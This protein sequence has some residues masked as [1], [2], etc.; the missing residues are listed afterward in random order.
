LSKLGS[1]Y[2]RFG[3]HKKPQDPREVL[4]HPGSGGN[5]DPSQG[6]GSGSDI[7]AAVA[8]A[9]DPGSIGLYV[10]S[11]LLV[12]CCW[13]IWV[14]LYPLA[15]GAG[16]ATFLI[17]LAFIHKITL[18]L[19]GPAGPDGILG[20]AGFLGA[21]LVT[22]VMLV[23]VSRSEHRLARPPAIPVSA[24]SGATAAFGNS[25][26]VE[27]HGEKPSP[28]GEPVIPGQIGKRENLHGRD[29]GLAFVAVQGSAL[30]PV[31]ACNAAI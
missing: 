17:L 29:P 28:F 22:V 16:A 19:Y 18:S 11:F 23:I 31:L 14:C 27:H 26:S 20:A 24:T 12:C 25:G 15:A 1:D 3:P 6:I 4:Q 9:G 21:V 2:F 8:L 5:S 7:P 10:G 13:P 30:A